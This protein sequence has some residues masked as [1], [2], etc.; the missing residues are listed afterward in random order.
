MIQKISSIPLILVLVN[1]RQL[2]LFESEDSLSY[3]ARFLQ[4]SRA[5]QWD[6]VNKQTRKQKNQKA[7]LFSSSENI[8]SFPESSLK[9]HFV[10]GITASFCFL[11][12]SENLFDWYIVSSQSILAD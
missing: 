11:F 5:I 7:F 2:K 9:F 12:S 6:Y 10:S 3:I 4:I 8:T 1:Q